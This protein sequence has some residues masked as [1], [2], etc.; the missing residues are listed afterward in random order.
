MSHSHTPLIDMSQGKH[1]SSYI[2]GNPKKYKIMMQTT[3]TPLEA[4]FG[5]TGDSATGF[6]GA[7]AGAG[8]AGGKRSL[9]TSTLSTS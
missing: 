1:Q 8:G 5:A 4:S 3:I 7:G 6:A 2:H 9:G